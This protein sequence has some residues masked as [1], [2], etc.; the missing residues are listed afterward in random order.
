[1]NSFL[2]WQNS[3]GESDSECL[4]VSFSKLRVNFTLVPGYLQYPQLRACRTIIRTRPSSPLLTGSHCPY[5]PPHPPSPNYKCPALLTPHLSATTH[6]TLF[7][8]SL[9]VIFCYTT[10]REIPPSPNKTKFTPILSNQA[11]RNRG[12]A[13]R[14]GLPI[15]ARAIL[16]FTCITW[17]LLLWPIYRDLFARNTGRSS[18]FS[19]LRRT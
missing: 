1:M 6:R 19:A 18:N 11:A 10:T 12:R 9:A 5:I 17:K 14:S 13:L 4:L 15:Q 2:A 8:P 16:Y 7:K 3:P